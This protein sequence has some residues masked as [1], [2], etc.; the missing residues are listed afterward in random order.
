MIQK[1]HGLALI[2]FCFCMVGRAFGDDRG[3]YFSARELDAAYRYQE[4]FGQRLR[5]P[6]KPSGCYMGQSEI[7]A[8]FQGKKI[9]VSC[10]FITET[11]RHLR[12]MFEQGAAKYLF[13][14]DMD[15][16]DIVIPRPLWVN[17]YSSLARD[18]GLAQLL[19]EPRLVAIYHTAQ[20]LAIS[21]MTGNE[22]PVPKEPR[23]KS[24]VWGFFDGSPIKIVPSLA[25]HSAHSNSDYHEVALVHFLGHRLGEFV[26]SANSKAVSFDLSFDEDF[27]V[28][29]P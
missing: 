8:S 29:N 11:T 22:S 4:Q 9:M 10:R 26:F 2:M 6:I 27:A 20:H 13:P 19:R 21:I 17:K 14:L 7:P 5:Y 18:E 15:F 16:A 23:T 3:W 25:Y 12:L 1:L 28:L 24:D